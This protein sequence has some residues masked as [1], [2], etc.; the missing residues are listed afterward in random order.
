[1]NK[2]GIENFSVEKIEECS[3][4]ELSKR[5]RYW[6]EYFGTFKYGYNATLGGDGKQYIDYDLVIASY[7]Q[8]QNQK[9]VAKLLNI[10]PDSV[11]KILA[12]RKI[13]KKSSQEIS[14]ERFGIK[15]KM[16]D[17]NTHEL[18]KVFSSRNEAAQWLI[19]NKKTNCKKTTIG[20]HIIEVC[21]KKR[22]SAAGYY[23]EKI[24]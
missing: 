15:V 2:Y 8:L 24:E 12:L 11:S 19:D 6:I 9:E 17:K 16:C 5:E 14:K 18:L 22:K 1:M 4:K 23:W 21:N 7:N 3:E 13:D 20:Y 10:S